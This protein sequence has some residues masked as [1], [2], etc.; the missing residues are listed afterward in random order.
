MNETG[1]GEEVIGVFALHATKGRTREAINNSLCLITNL[2][3]RLPSLVTWI[4]TGMESI[5][6]HGNR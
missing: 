2:S 4:L 3:K 1:G 5:G 6:L